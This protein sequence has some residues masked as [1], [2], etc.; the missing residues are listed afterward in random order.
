MEE[1]KFELLAE[2][3]D[4]FNNRRRGYQYFIDNTIT[5]HNSSMGKKVQFGS[6]KYNNTRELML[7][8]DQNKIM[9]VDIPLSEINT[10]EL[11]NN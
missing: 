5:P 8:T 10:N 9:T 1:Y 11:I 3:E 2:G 4:S 6:K 7:S